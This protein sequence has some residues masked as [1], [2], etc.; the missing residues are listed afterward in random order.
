MCCQTGD[1]LNVLATNDAPV[2]NHASLGLAVFGKEPGVNLPGVQDL[3]GMQW[4]GCPQAHRGG[5]WPPAVLLWARC[6][7]PSTRTGSMGKLGLPDGKED[8]LW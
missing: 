6:P 1:H 8:G 3:M 5:C 4:C 2:S 7:T